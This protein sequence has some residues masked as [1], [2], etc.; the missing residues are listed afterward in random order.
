[1]GPLKATERRAALLAW[2]R[3]RPTHEGLT[4]EQ[5]VDVI[6][7]PYDKVGHYDCSRCFAD[8]LALFDA[9]ELVRYDT[10]PARWGTVSV[11]RANSCPECGAPA[12]GRCQLE[13]DGECPEGCVTPEQW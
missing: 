8:L 3:E 10:R 4:A 1:M 2:M 12:H 5:I 7:H 13:G 11:H 9:G 6:G